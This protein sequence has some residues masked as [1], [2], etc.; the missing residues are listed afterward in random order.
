MGRVVRPEVVRVGGLPIVKMP[1]RT[2]LVRVGTRSRRPVEGASCK[3]E[4]ERNRGVLSSWPRASR[5][6]VEVSRPLS[7]ALFHLWI[8]FCFS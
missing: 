4:L 1:Y 2:G 3:S 7:L 5:S 8:V 6:A